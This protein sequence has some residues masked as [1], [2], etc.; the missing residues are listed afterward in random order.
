MFKLYFE[1]SGLVYPPAFTPPLCAPLYPQASP[2]SIP[3]FSYLLSSLTCSS[4]SLPNLSCLLFSVFSSPSLLTLSI[5]FT[6][7]LLSLSVSLF[8]D[9]S[10]WSPCGTPCRVPNLFIISALCRDAPGMLKYTP[11]RSGYKWAD[12]PPS[13]LPAPAAPPTRPLGWTDLTSQ[14]QTQVLKII[15]TPQR[16]K[17]CAAGKKRAI[18]KSGF[19]NVLE[20]VSEIQFALNFCTHF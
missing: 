1:D 19:K 2:C 15:T 4:M 3:L 10:C 12:V 14:S 17:L 20:H 11:P 16:R 5:S 13:F 9:C 7:P 6:Q 18:L 8:C